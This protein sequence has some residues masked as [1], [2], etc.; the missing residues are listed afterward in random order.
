MPLFL[1][2]CIYLPHITNIYW[3][4]RLQT[5]LR[6]PRSSHTQISPFI[7]SLMGEDKDKL[8]QIKQLSQ[9]KL[10]KLDASETPLSPLLQLCLST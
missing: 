3:E 1:K 2:N 5:E 9:L 4:T 10:F 7:D 6:R 8:S